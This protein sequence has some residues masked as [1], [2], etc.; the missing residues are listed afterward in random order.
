LCKRDARAH[1]FQEDVKASPAISTGFV[2]PEKIVMNFIS[3]RFCAV[4]TGPRGRPGV[5]SES[6]FKPLDKRK[7]FRRYLVRWSCR[8]CPFG[9]QFYD[10]CS[11]NIT[12]K[13][14]DLN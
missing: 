11:G 8:K 12:A 4:C 7:N 10:D 3:D 9:D 5:G 2:G 6:R 13:A 1:E 14:V